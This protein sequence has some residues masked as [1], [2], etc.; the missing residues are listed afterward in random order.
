MR[1]AVAL[2]ALILAFA[3]SAL[4]Q[5]RIAVVTTTTDLR[6]LVEAVGGEAVAATSLVPPQ[7]DA[8]DYQPRPQDLLR[9]KAAAVLVR[10]GLDYDLWLDRL[11]AQVARPEISR[12]GAGYVDASSAIAVLE[13]RGMSVGRG[14]G[15]AH[16][17]GN[18][19]YWLDPS[20]AETISATILEALAR[21][22]TTSAPRYTTNRAA[23][24]ARLR[25]RLPE[26]Q[27]RLAPARGVGIVAYHNSWPY[28]ARRFRLD[29]VDFI[30]IK[31]GV[32]PTAAHLAGLIA[33]MPARN[34]RIV[35]RGPQDP[36]RDAAFLANK[37]GA[38]VLTLA[39]SVGGLPR[40]TDYLA[41]FDTNV[42]ALA[43][44]AAQ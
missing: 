7:I 14:D 3:P 10:V 27:A 25:A 26:W 36:E 18:P 38:T 34:V 44:A 28:F 37:V 39:A 20:N 17:S 22:D 4:A 8:E 2:V 5:A 6:S 31:P 41:L 29:F 35:V 13:V 42:D 24:V 11:L 1:R 19:H 15:H 33:R 12:G 21:I 23:F 16:G 43:S 9:L 40:A 30:E 32:P